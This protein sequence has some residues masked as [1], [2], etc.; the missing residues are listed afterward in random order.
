MWEVETCTN[1]VAKKDYHCQ[2]SDWIDN[3]SLQDDEL[4]E[5]DLKTIRLAKDE[6]NRI[7]KGTKYVKITGK[8]EGEWSVFRAREDLDDICTRHEIYEE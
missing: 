3:V 8:W 5:E 6:N 4:G 2:A 1:P 7:L